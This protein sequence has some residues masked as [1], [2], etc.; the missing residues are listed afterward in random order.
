[1]FDS[2]HRPHLAVP[3]ST[4]GTARDHRVFGAK[5]SRPTTAACGAS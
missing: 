3:V 5:V 2:P 4:G 1:M